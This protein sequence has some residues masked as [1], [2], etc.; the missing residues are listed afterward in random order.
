MIK[1]VHEIAQVTEVVIQMNK[2]GEIHMLNNHNQPFT[3]I[4]LKF[5]NMEK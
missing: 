4:S 5:A 1:N 2:V 3:T